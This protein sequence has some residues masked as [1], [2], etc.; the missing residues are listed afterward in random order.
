MSSLRVELDVF[1]GRANPSWALTEAQASDLLQRLERLA[2][3]GEPP[4]AVLGYRGFM[5]YR[6]AQQSP[7]LR[8]AAG[9]V[10]VVDRRQPRSYRDSEGIEDWLRDQAI[11]RGFGALVGG[12]R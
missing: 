10:H 12:A 4:E 3:G 8:V 11:A 1:S 9:M 6:A 2:P 7:W 5:V